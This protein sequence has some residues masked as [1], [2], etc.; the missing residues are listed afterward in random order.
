MRMLFSYTWVLDVRAPFILEQ[1]RNELKN[2]K[3]KEMMHLVIGRIMY[4]QVHVKK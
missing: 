3:P 1:I 4:L 2:Q